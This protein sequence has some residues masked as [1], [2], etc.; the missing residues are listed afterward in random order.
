MT[1]HTELVLVRHGETEWNSHRRCQ[2]H[3]DIPLSEQGMR[4]S[5]AVAQAVA[6]GHW[7]ALYSSDLARASMTAQAIA[8]TTG[9]PVRLDER[10]RER[11]LGILQGLTHTEF[12]DRHPEDFAA[13]YGND[14]DWVIPGGESQQ[15]ASDRMVGAC[16]S[17]ANAHPGQRVLVVTHGGS[18]G[19]L[20]KWV[21]GLPAQHARRWS[22]FNC[23]LHTFHVRGD[24]WRMVRWGETAHLNDHA[25]MDGVSL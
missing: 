21:M 25:A 16:Q 19:C 5:R 10:L 2:G 24:D 1:E 14:S 6:G 3:L 8:E 17:I 22:I 9:L 12:R 13:F 4:Q 18:I 15:Q 23:A 7:A 20:M 11:A